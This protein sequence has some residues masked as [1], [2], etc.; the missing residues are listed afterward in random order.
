LISSA[1]LV[2]WA[3]FFAHHFMARCEFFW[4]KLCDFGE[5]KGE[6]GLRGF[7]WAKKRA[8]PTDFCFLSDLAYPTRLPITSYGL[9]YF[10][11]TAEAA[12]KF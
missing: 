9:I 7:R 2:G 1:S 3:R 4:G 11:N 10:L 6:Q 5:W 12:L 8:H